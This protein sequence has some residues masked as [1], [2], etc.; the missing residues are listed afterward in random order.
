MLSRSTT[1]PIVIS[2]PPSPSSWH[3][4][5]PLLLI[6]LPTQSNPLQDLLP[7]LVR[8][9]LGDL[10]LAGGDADGDALA[11]AL[12]AGDSL[13]VH[14]VFEAV[15]GDDLALAALVAAALDHHFV[16]FADGDCADLE[17]YC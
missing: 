4:R 14:D 9:D 7:I 10:E 17:E 1:R 15:D 3:S 6:R 5:L 16:V 2:T 13:N 12:L 8:L 11:V